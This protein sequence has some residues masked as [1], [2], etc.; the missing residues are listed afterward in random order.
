[1]MQRSTQDDFSPASVPQR[2]ERDLESA[3]SHVPVTTNRRDSPEA[4]TRNDTRWI[5]CLRILFFGTLA[6]VAV[7]ISL[8]TYEVLYRTEYKTFQSEFEKTAAR[9]QQLFL[10]DLSLKLWIAHLALYSLHEI[11]S[12]L[13]NVNLQFLEDLDLA[14]A[15]TYWER[16][17]WSPLLRTEAERETWEAYAKQTIKESR[18]ASNGVC[19]VC[20]KGMQVGSPNSVVNVPGEGDISCNIVEWGGLSGYIP[21]VDCDLIS[22]IMAPCQCQKATANSAAKVQNTTMP[23][24]ADFIFGIK[25]GKEVS[26]ERGPYSPIWQGVPRAPNHALLYDQMSD[27]FRRHALMAMLDSKLPTFTHISYPGDDYENMLTESGNTPMSTVYFPVFGNGAADNNIIGS[28][29]LDFTWQSIFGYSEK[30]P[31]NSD[32]IVLVIESNQGQAFTFQIGDN[33]T[34]TLVSVGDVHDTKFDSM[35]NATTFE[36]LYDVILRASQK[37][38]VGIN[39]TA[40]LYSLSVYPSDEFMSLFVTNKPAIYTCLVAAI[41]VFTSAIFILYDIFVRRRQTKVMES[42]IQANAIVTSLFPESIRSRLM[43]RI[44]PRPGR[45]KKL[46]QVVAPK[47]QLR[48][49]LKGLH[50]RAS[51]IQKAADS[52]SEPIADF[53]PDTTVIFADIAG[54]TAWSS[55]REPAQVF[56]LLETVYRTFDEIAEKLGV[57]KIETIGDCYVAVTGLPEPQADHAVRMARFAHE[58]MMSMHDL[59]GSLE[60][61]LGPG[62]GSLTIRVGLHSGPVTGGV[63]RGDKARFQLFGDTMNTAARMQT[64]G[65]VRRI[66]TTDSTAT[67]LREAG[68][69]HWL[70]ERDTKVAVKGKGEMQTFWVDLNLD[71]CASFDI[72][73][74]MSTSKTEDLGSDDEIICTQLPILIEN[75]KKKSVTASLARLIAF[76]VDLLER[77]LKGVVASRAKTKR[78]RPKA[79]HDDT[80][81]ESG[82]PIEEVT[83]ILAMSKPV[84]EHIDLEA[85]EL[86]EAVRTELREYVECVAR[87]YRDNPFHNFEHASHVAMSAS[88]IV[89]RIVK[90]DNVDY[91]QQSLKKKNR[92]KAV[93]Q[94]IHLSTFGISSDALMQ[95]AAIFAAVIH[96][97]DHTGVPNV[98]LTKEGD[99]VAV[100][101]SNK[102]VAEQHSVRTAWDLLMEDRF[103]NLRG[104]I[105]ASAEEKARFRQ[106]VVN[107]VIATDIADAELQQLRKNRWNKAFHCSHNAP[108]ADNDTLSRK[109]TVVFEYII[110]A[111][112]VAHTMQ[113][114][115]VYCK[116]NERL[117]HERCRAYVAGREDED[118]SEGWYKGEIGFF[119]NYVIPLARNLEACGVFGVS[120]E[121]YLNYALEN[122]REW[123]LKGRNIV[124]GLRVKYSPSN[125]QDNGQSDHRTSMG[126]AIV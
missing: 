85:V 24:V 71:G 2:D 88:K 96:D 65:D 4:L 7:S 14:Q 86:S 8:A 93:A 97:V 18:N 12:G 101:Y 119:D 27:P 22:A 87:K 53:F 102:S 55:E 113:H 110:Q 47:Q 26:E 114:W 40:L 82:N 79:S 107:A 121:E 64:T 20:G 105:F 17:G 69:G 122:R 120:S 46:E 84:D 83:E 123:E 16:V 80:S 59:V 98:R 45:G 39:Q 9:I 67:L 91:H 99:D 61:T 81:S 34:A 42:A 13:V 106:L 75:G 57:F 108:I 100:K 52:S 109:A 63:L 112:D 104:S 58:I 103:E 5:N 77:F 29:A 41:F 44:I 78:E 11:S 118:P 72:S 56:Q 111:S 68:F 76:N 35:M 60:S 6:V 43:G 74:E 31:L 54:F 116:W 33:R 3:P 70:Q 25:N 49:M 94:Q 117:F 115:H 50:R 73:K 28:L 10:Q 21:S 23:H 32:G 124:E 1:M 62:T 48:T 126:H 90:P 95:F 19:Y 89:K 51:E 38:D 66:Q 92:S 36:E 125:Q 37:S 30:L 15:I